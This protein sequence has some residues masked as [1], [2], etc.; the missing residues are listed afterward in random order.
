MKTRETRRVWA[1]G[2]Y[3]ANGDSDR[4]TNLCVT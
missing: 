3:L 1:A 2:G 4:V